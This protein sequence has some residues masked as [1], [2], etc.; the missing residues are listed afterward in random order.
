MAKHQ[1][2]YILHRYDSPELLIEAAYWWIM[3]HKLDHFE[4]AM[5]IKQLIFD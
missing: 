2:Q 5:K 3:W 1:D 4:K